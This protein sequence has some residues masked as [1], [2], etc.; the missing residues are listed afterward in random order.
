MSVVYQMGNEESTDTDAPP[1]IFDYLNPD[2]PR[3]DL[4]DPYRI[5]A[6]PEVE[7]SE[8]V[9]WYFLEVLPPAFYGG[10]RFVIREALTDH[11]DGRVIASQYSQRGERY[12]HRYI[13][14]DALEWRKEVG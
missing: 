12:Y 5:L 10:G 4:F 2:L 14:I 1:N 8:R 3:K 7:V 13:A 11:P 9:Y 6:C